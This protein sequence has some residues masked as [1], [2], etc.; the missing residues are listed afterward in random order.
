MD[1]A[2]T[3][4]AIKKRLISKTDI[5]DDTEDDL[6]MVDEL[7]KAFPELYADRQHGI[8]LITKKDCGNFNSDDNLLFLKDIP[9]D[10]GNRG[11]N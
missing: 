6:A 7:K 3:K 10:T 1:R 9:A 11:N 5:I 4:M 2:M 8:E